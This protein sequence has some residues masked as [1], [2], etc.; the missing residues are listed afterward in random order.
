MGNV[1]GGN[2]KSE[3]ISDPQEDKH[4]QIVS[5]APASDIDDEEHVVDDEEGDSHSNSDD[6]FHDDDEE[7][8]DVDD[9]LDMCHM[10]GDEN[11]EDEDGDLLD[12]EMNVEV[13][14]VKPWIGSIFEPE[15]PPP[16]DPSLP[17]ATMDLEW[18]YGF[19]CHD[20]RDNIALFGKTI[21]YPQAAVVVQYN[22]DEHTQQ[23][24]RDHNDD[25]MCLAQAKN[26]PNIIATGQIAAL[27]EGKK[28]RRS[29]QPGIC[30]WD[31]ATNEVI[32]IDNAAK[33]CVRTIALS[34]DGD[35]VCCVGADNEFTVN[36][37]DV[38]T[39]SSMGSEKSGNSKIYSAVWGNDP[40]TFFIAGDKT[41]QQWSLMN[42]YPE[43][44][45]LSFG[46]GKY[47]K[48]SRTAHLS[49]CTT[50]KGYLITCTNKGWVCAFK[51]GKCFK[52]KQVSKRALYTCNSFEQDN[53]DTH[54]LFGGYDGV[55]Y[56]YNHK[57]KLVDQY[58]I[59]EK[60]CSIVVQE[61]LC[62]IGTRS[63][64]IYQCLD[65]DN[66][67]EPVVEG[68]CD[69]ELWAICECPF[70]SNRFYTVGEDNQ[71]RIWDKNNRKCLNQSIIDPEKI[72]K[73]KRRRVGTTSTEP[74]NRCARAITCSPDGST[75]AI[76]CNTGS[77]RLYD[78]ESLDFMQAIDLNKKGKRKV[79]N[80]ADNWIECM[81][82]S[83]DG[84]F[85][86][87]GT[88]GMVICILDVSDGYSVGAVLKSHNAPICNL[89]WSAD[90]EHLQ[91]VCIAYELLFFDIDP[92][93]LSSSCQNTRPS[94][95]T[96]IEWATQTCKFGWPVQGVFGFTVD[97]TD[98]NRCAKDPNNQ[99][100]FTATDW[101][102]VSMFR[103]PCLEGHEGHRFYG[104][105][106]HVTNVIVQDKHVFTTGGNDKAIFQWNIQ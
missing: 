105:S 56:H 52:A 64:N 86:A 99:W 104:H 85:L 8:S 43:K 47:S 101:G 10:F 51:D 3:Q 69:G 1:C 49:A 57:L 15:N 35:R 32:Q 68:H 17:S 39:G 24:M 88:H 5:N 84:R 14:S 28:A 37:F 12:D 65:F 97:G 19:R 46:T 92:D 22:R 58:D 21:V 62:C 45:K 44:K 63:G 42:G 106:S 53:G 96:H 95:L 100:L 41:V 6:E 38:G 40:D 59:G 78:A 75:V 13:M 23:Y 82:Y 18:V 2:S 89:D 26:A 90:G 98:V 48:H 4:S 20:S 61:G 34:P 70:D 91:S 72:K 79:T 27:V 103:Y 67:G 25:V 102:Y 55:L 7:F 83:P 76:G 73:K 11:E 36:C 33:R 30:I 93:N 50:S 94:A 81:A 31:V 16:I 80:Q 66:L 9:E 71:L 60:I 87:V 74:P 77:V 54:F 29:Q